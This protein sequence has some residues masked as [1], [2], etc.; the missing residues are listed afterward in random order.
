[1]ARRRHPGG[2]DGRGRAGSSGVLRLLPSVGCV[3]EARWWLILIYRVPSEP[4]R[5]RNTVWRR[6]KG[7]GAVYLQSAAAALPHS[8]A[9]ERALRSLRNEITEMGGSA[10]LLRAEALAGEADIIDAFNTA[11]DE[12]YTELLD[13]CQDFL[14]EIDRETKG[15]KFTYAEL[16]EIDEDLTKLRGWLAKVADRDRFAA[17]GRAA[18]TDALA[19]CEAAFEEFTAEVYDANRDQ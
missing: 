14:A 15:E 10:Q 2:V 4:T 7:L 11:R 12:E 9:T 16:E 18:V 19:A 5:L 3:G 1:M 8:A 17:A 13:R 6:L